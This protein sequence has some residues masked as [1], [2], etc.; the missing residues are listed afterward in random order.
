MKYSVEAGPER[1]ALRHHPARKD[2]SVRSGARLTARPSDRV[3]LAAARGANWSFDSP[4]NE[5][6][7]K[8]D[9]PLSALVVSTRACTS[10][11]N[12]AVTRSLFRPRVA[13]QFR[14][15]L[16]A[17]ASLGH[18]PSPP[19]GRRATSSSTLDKD[20]LLLL[21]VLSIRRN[22][23]SFSF[24][25]SRKRAWGPSSFRRSL[26]TRQWMAGWH[27]TLRNPL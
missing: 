27:R 15:R 17:N 21:A 6:G 3:H 14:D 4:R 11:S 22:S 2:G 18:T 16:D 23:L 24:L 20:H 5:C 1:G 7:R 12:L 9:W 25:N 8:Y 13:I 10:A 26:R 19:T